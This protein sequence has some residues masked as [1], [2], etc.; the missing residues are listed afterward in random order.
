ML[1]NLHIETHEPGLAELNWTMDGGNIKSLTQFNITSIKLNIAGFK[2]DYSFKWPLIQGQGKYLMDGLFG[3]VLPVFGHGGFEYVENV[4]F[5]LAT[6]LTDYLVFWKV[7][8]RF[9]FS[10]RPKESLGSINKLGI[11]FVGLPQS[12]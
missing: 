10:S 12:E 11:P 2:F 3:G 8:H 6:S 9:C 7:C 4:V 5:I 1:N